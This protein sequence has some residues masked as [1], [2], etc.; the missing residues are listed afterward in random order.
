MTYESDTHTNLT[1]IKNI[2]YVSLQYRLHKIT[3]NYLTKKW[4]GR[5]K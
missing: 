4:E 1:L 3:T 5:I 2:K